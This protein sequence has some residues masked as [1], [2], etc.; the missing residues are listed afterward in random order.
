MPRASGDDDDKPPRLASFSLFSNR[1][2]GP[3]G[4]LRDAGRG[5]VGVK[6]GSDTIRLFAG[7]LQMLQEF[8]LTPEMCAARF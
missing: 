7:A 8:H 6:S 1:R 2:L 4:S 5:V 3:Q